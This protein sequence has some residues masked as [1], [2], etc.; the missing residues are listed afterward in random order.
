MRGLMTKLESIVRE[1]H[2]TR[3]KKVRVWLGA[4]SHFSAE[5][6]REHFEEAS[7]GTL[8]EDAAIEIEVS[9]NIVDPRAQDVILESI[10]VEVAGE[11]SSH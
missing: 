10:D 5:H 6:F 9:T 11:A 8:A 3:V 1:Q 7:R 4:L 2:A